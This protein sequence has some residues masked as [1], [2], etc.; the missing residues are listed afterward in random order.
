MTSSKLSSNEYAVRLKT[1][2]DESEINEINPLYVKQ[3]TKLWLRLR[4]L[5]IFTGSSLYKGL[6]LFRLSD[7]QEFLREH[8]NKG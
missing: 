8:V 4:K 3:G 2:S 6:G 5:S 1:L 7:Q